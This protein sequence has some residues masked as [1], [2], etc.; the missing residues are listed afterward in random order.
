MQFALSRLF[1]RLYS[2]VTKMSKPLQTHLEQRLA[3]SHTTEY[4]SGV[5]GCWLCGGASSVEFAPSRIPDDLTPALVNPSDSRYGFTAR[6]L[7][8]T[9]CGF[10]RAEKESAKALE[11]LYQKLVDNEYHD[12]IARRRTFANILRRIRK[13]NPGAVN[14]LD[15]GAGTGIFCDQAERAGF[16]AV[17]VEP[18]AWAVA[19]GRRRYGI[20]LHEGYF[21]HPDV[22]NRQFDVVTM[23]DVIEHV[24][25]PVEILQAARRCVSP[26]GLLVVVTPDISSLAARVMGPRWW[27]LRPAHIGYFSR[28]TMEAAL[29][30]AGF[31][32]E[33]LESYTWWFPLGYLVKRLESYLPIGPA[34]RFL[35]AQRWLAPLWQASIPLSLR[36]SH[37]YFARPTEV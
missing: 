10:I 21:P 4:S 14:L 9:D 33:R 30:A 28:Q 12:T 15:I 3:E 23:C 20:T 27:H 32:L 31:T 8:C 5:D 16:R 13:L 18:S 29:G 24:S 6:L 25:Q 7:Q 11:S 35:A 22:V 17:G 19:E 37:I 36:D 1:S 26:G 34:S 2:I